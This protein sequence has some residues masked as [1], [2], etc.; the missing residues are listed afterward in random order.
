MYS[1]QTEFGDCFT[2][3]TVLVTGAT[4]F[5]GQAICH[6]LV[7][8]GARVHGLARSVDEIPPG[9]VRWAV[10]L[11][12]G[13]RVDANYREISPEVV[14]HLAAQVTARQEIDLV[15]TMCEH[16]LL[17]TM[18][19]LL[20]AVQHKCRRIVTAGT[21]EEPSGDVRRA[22]VGSPYAAAKTAASIYTQ[23]FHRLYQLPVVAVRPFLTYGPGQ[24][25][26]KLVPYT[27][28]K[29][30]RG[31]SPQLT[32]GKRRCD[33]VYLRDVV[34]GMLRAAVAPNI[35]GQTF[36]LGSGHAMSIRSAVE[37]IASLI[38]RNVPV[39]FGAISDRLGEKALIADS[40]TTQRVLGWE[41]RWTLADGMTETIAWYAERIGVD[42]PA[43][44]KKKCA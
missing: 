16:N 29:L 15:R 25:E 17:G 13:A 6:A 21:P 44:E 39:H 18:N 41:P 7:A 23:M 20:A 43:T 11:R 12:D 28:L 26:T 4:G 42:Y 5:A 3:R 38:G 30:L 40:Q 27:I 35:E 34:R 19:L 10:D 8:L 2:G 9:V 14:F 32:S 37:Q 1:W 24:D 36:D 33:F 31:E 22:I